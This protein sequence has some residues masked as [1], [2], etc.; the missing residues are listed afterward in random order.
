MKLSP[1]EIEARVAELPGWS[2]E[3]DAL[4]RRLTL[5]SFADAVAFVT[6]LAFDA[7]AADHHP[8]LHVSYTRVTVTWSTHSAGG[9]TEKDVRGARQTDALAGR[10]CD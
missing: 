10:L 2:V 6:R 9:I 4:V 8:D 7:E 3:G 1:A 5:P